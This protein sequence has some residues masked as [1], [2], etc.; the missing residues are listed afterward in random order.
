MLGL[1]LLLG[2]L[3]LLVP[4]G[5][6]RAEDSG[7][8]ARPFTHQSVI[9]LAQ[10]LAQS[11]FQR[12]PRAP[13]ALTSLDYATYRQINYQSDAAVWGQSPTPFSVQLFAPGF[14]YDKLV[15]I[16]IVENGQA[17]PLAVG[18]DS[19]RVP[20]PA[21]ATLLAQVGKY[22]GMRLH[23]PLNRPDYDD[24]FLVFQG[25]SFFR[26][27]SRGQLYGLSARGLAIDVAEPGGEE[28]PV[29]RR[30]WIERPATDQQAMVVH[31]LL[32]SER[33]TGAYRFGIYPGQPLR[34]EVEATLF[35]R[36]YLPH[37]GL[38]PLTSMFM[39]GPADPA[40]QPDYR[41]AVHDSEGLAIQRSNGERL[42]RPL[43]NP[44]T[45]QASA[46]L[47]DNPAGFGLIQ[48][49]RE[50]GAYQDLEAKYHRRPSAWV[51]PL[52]DWGKG[53]V[54]L[55]E[56][57]SDSEA[58]D[59]MVA[60]W[61]PENG[62]KAGE[63]F[64]FAYRLTWPDDAPRAPGQARIVRSAGGNKLFSGQR[65]IMIDWAGSEDC[66]Q[67]AVDAGISEGRIIETTLQPHPG[68]AGCRAFIA[69]DPGEAQAAELRV[70]LLRGDGSPAG[71]TWLYR[72]LNEA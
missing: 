72:W 21:L 13:E 56:I 40:D 44:R 5:P 28:H 59:N 1:A 3:L 43:T 6:A 7:S 50:L 8:A 65:E 57:P 33:V 35:P 54:Q 18:P 27:V 58:N 4:G 66:A 53:Q 36:Q 70:M 42:W 30:F 61:R 51:E 32:D 12:L 39:H 69:F 62:L 2:L 47:D 14:L 23:Y 15:D 22:A 55:V 11:P 19:F 16:D 71:E 37:V 26:G 46:F 10:T 29:F 17:Q 25:A 24:E 67:L 31:A 52:G 41:P 45:L 48:R 49:S 38:A 64:H 63:P 9:D 34:M 60:Y 20:D 68:I